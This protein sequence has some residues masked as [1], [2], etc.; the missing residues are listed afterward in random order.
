MTLYECR[1]TDCWESWRHTI[2]RT[3]KGAYE[4]GRKWL[5]NEFNSNYEA[6]A[7]IGKQPDQF[8]GCYQ[9]FRVHEVVVQD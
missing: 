3:R 9:T 1:V 2:H 6:R 5:L 4:S 8:M 7:I